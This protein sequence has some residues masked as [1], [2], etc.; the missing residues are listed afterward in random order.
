MHMGTV[1]TQIPSPHLWGPG[2]AGL[3]QSLGPEIHEILLIM[4]NSDMYKSITN[5]LE[6]ITQLQRNTFMATWIYKFNMLFF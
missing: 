6:Y 1:R 5:T 3:G 2:L 4:E